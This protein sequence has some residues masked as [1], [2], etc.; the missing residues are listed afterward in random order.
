MTDETDYF[1]SADQPGIDRFAQRLR[2]YKELT[3]EDAH[4]L[5]RHWG[6][7]VFFQRL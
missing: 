5:P 7:T 2:V 1:R 3:Q 6:A 4:H